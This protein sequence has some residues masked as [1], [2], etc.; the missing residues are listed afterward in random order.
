MSGKRNNNSMDSDSGNEEEWEAS[1]DVYDFLKKNEHTE[2]I[3]SIEGELCFF[4][5]IGNILQQIIN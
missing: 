5:K 2:Q 3:K 1:E 4:L